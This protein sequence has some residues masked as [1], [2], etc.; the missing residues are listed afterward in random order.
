MLI[1]PSFGL[2]WNLVWEL[3][4]SLH[5]GQKILKILKGFE[6]NLLK[7]LNGVLTSVPNRLTM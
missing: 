4:S 2:P 3:K 1:N 7:N 5:T 6:L